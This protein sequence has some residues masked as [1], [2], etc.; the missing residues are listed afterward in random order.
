MPLHVRIGRLIGD[1]LVAQ[2]GHQPIEHD[3]GVLVPDRRFDLVRPQVGPD[4]VDQAWRAC[5]AANRM[6]QHRTAWLI[7]GPFRMSAEF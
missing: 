6:D 5:Q 4:V 1:A 7:A 2:S 3:G